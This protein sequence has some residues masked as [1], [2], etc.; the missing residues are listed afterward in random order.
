[1]EPNG[2]IFT[3]WEIWK[4]TERNNRG[5]VRDKSRHSLTGTRKPTRLSAG[6][7][8]V[9]AKIGTRHFRNTVTL[10]PD[11]TCSV[12]LSKTLL[13]YISSSMGVK[14]GLVPQRKNTDWEYLR[15]KIIW[16]NWVSGAREQQESE[17]N[18][19]V[20][21]IICTLRQ[22]LWLS[23]QGGWDVLC[24]MHGSNTFRAP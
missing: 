10:P 6:K 15:T 12:L 24:D 4:Y 21:F 9:P 2:R 1:M 19:V 14:L 22:M 18:H 20:I 16:E 11:S 17:E 8:C 5:L 7:V 13:F 3:E 23:K